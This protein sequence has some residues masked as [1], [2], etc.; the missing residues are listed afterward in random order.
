MFVGLFDP[1]IHLLEQ[2]GSNQIKLD[3]IG[4]NWFKLD[5]KRSR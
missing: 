1:F 4:S 3:Q 2:F 5:Q